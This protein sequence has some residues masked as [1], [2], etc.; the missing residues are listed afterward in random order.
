MAAHWCIQSQVM[1]W[2]Q[3]LLSSTHRAYTSVLASPP[4]A[5][6]VMNFDGNKSHM[7]LKCWLSAGAQKTLGVQPQGRLTIAVP[8]L[9]DENFVMI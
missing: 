9:S 4:F 1:G 2:Q 3:L 8:V 7:Q 5:G 6:H